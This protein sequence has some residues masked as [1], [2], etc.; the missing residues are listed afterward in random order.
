MSKTFFSEFKS[1]IPVAIINKNDY[2]YDV[3]KNVFNQYGFGF[4][5]PFDNLIVID[6]EAGLNKNELKWVEAHEVAHYLLGHSKVNPND[7]IEADTL[8]YNMLNERGYT[9]SA[10]MVKDTF[11]ERHG[12]DFII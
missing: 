10:K 5:L 7:E 2:R 9:K 4:M 3:L 11:L 12:I 6:G 8:A 1:D